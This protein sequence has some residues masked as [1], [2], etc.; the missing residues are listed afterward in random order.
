MS[1]DMAT[2]GADID[3]LLI[4]SMETPALEIVIGRRDKQW[5]LLFSWCW[6]Y[7]IETLKDYCLITPDLGIDAII[8][9]IYSLKIYSFY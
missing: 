1:K 5:V 3:G 8:E 4:E 7:L 9:S 6:W 2:L